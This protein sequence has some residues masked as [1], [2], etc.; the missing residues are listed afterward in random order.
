M[1]TPALLFPEA[2]DSPGLWPEL[3][4][5]HGLEDKDFRWLADVRLASDSLRRQQ[6]PPMSAERILLTADNQRS[7][8]RRGGKECRSRWSP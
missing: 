8:E 4:R 3:G 2:L 5:I 7:E 6:R 1:P